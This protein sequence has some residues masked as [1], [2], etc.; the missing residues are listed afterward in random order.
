MPKPKSLLTKS[1]AMAICDPFLTPKERQFLHAIGSLSKYR[2]PV[3]MFPNGSWGRVTIKSLTRLRLI[4]DAG[5]CKD[6][7]LTQTGSDLLTGRR[8]WFKYGQTPERR[9]TLI[10]AKNL[11]QKIRAQG[12]MDTQPY[13]LVFTLISE[14]WP[15]IGEGE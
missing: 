7:Q 11:A 3:P 4:S 5:S 6:H 1:Q 10:K 9:I 14:C 15:E 12:L 2:K 13:K 8:R